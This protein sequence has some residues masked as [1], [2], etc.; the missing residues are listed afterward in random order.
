M[1]TDGDPTKS[2]NNSTSKLGK[3]LEVSKENNII[4]SKIVHPRVNWTT[5]NYNGTNMHVYTYTDENNI[6][7]IIV[8]STNLRLY[9]Y[10]EELYLKIGS[11]TY[12]AV[13]A[14]CNTAAGNGG[15]GRPQAA[16]N[17]YLDIYN[18]T[19]YGNCMDNDATA[20]KTGEKIT[21]K[22]N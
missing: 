16:K 7:Y 15:D 11:K 9:N 22:S 3:V 2:K 8:G 5:I 14:E 17:P 13:I 4:I 18:V 10:G 20:Y 21:L 6:S 12:R 19:D 1:T